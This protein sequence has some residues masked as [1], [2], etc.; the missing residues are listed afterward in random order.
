[1]SAQGM[2]ARPSA[3][4]LFSGSMA[5]ASRCKRRSCR[6]PL[7]AEVRVV[8]DLTRACVRVEEAGDGVGPCRCCR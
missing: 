5:R 7:V 2:K 8:D 6:G 4:S 3:T 1:M